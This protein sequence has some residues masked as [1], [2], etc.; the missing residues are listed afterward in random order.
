MHNDAKHRRPRISQFKSVQQF[1]QFHDTC[2]EAFNHM[3]ATGI[4]QMAERVRE[5]AERLA[6]RRRLSDPGTPDGER[7]FQREKTASK[8][9]TGREL[10]GNSRAARTNGVMA[11]NA[12]PS[13]QTRTDPDKSEQPVGYKNPPP[14]H[15]FKPGN[16]GGPGGQHGPRSMRKHIR[17]V[18]FGD[19]LEEG[20][21]KEVTKSLFLQAIKGNTHAIR[22]ICE[23]GNNRPNKAPRQRG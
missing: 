20:F 12:A 3:D 14:E 8:N 5:R 7:D 11:N 9:G 16:P 2:P 17:A 21:A 23:N 1:W 4:V 18:L 19:E 22:I 10:D 13:E 15:R 6:S